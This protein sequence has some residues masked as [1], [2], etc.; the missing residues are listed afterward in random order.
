MVL[1]LGAAIGAI[2]APDYWSFTILRF[3]V[4]VA[5]GGTMVTSFVLLMEFIGAQ[6]R[7]VIASLYQLP[8]NLGHTLL[9]LIA[10]LLRDNE[11]FYRDYQWALSVSAFVL[12][13]YFFVLP[14]TA[15]WLLAVKRTDEAI[16]VIEK[17]ARV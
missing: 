9:P 4:G 16:Q 15:R 2:Y 5:V 1:Q 10:Y 13:P 6:H 12:L 17:V 14:E 7:T 8:F 3:L 11:N